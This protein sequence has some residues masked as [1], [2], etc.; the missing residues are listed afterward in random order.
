VGWL[1]LPLGGAVGD[2][3]GDGGVGFVEVLAAQISSYVTGA[4]SRTKS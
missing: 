2:Q 4:L 3:A 1:E